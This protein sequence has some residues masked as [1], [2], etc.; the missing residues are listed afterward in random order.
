[1]Q[2]VYLFIGESFLADEALG[3]V[4]E[5]LGGDV[6]AEVGFDGSAP[7]HEIV[8]ALQT[9]SLLGGMRLVIVRDSQDL[10][11]DAIEALTGY[12][13][14]PAPHSVLVLFSSGRTKLDAAAKAAG[15]VIT[16][17]PPKGRKL[18]AW[19]KQQGVEHGLVVDERGAWALV[20]AVG[21]E[22]RDLDNALVQL[23]TSSEGAKIGA[24]H[25]NRMFP[26]QADERVYA[27]TDGVADRKIGPAMVALE[28][29]LRQG[30]S[31]LMLFG[32]LAGQVRRM[33]KARSF[34]DGGVRAVESGMGLPGWRA[35]R[36]YKQARSYRE[37]ELVEAVQ[38][39][40]EADVA[41]KSGGNDSVS[42]SILQRA[43][44]KIVG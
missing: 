28:R 4:R 11:K 36:L 29:L 21:N 38:L 43:V 16:L 17:D 35:E 39:L 34:V 33:L 42:G 3:R 20:D 25:V 18:V 31:P 8:G 37:D 24:A 26:R 10:G 7:G 19:V 12:L 9:A 41:M 27:F 6:S 44:V 30:E 32:A 40:A 13:E 5:E 2:P 15:T 22:L 1:M 23:S 14:S